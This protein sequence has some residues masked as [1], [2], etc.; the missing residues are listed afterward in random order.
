MSH[1]DGKEDK[2]E[3]GT[4]HGSDMVGVNG[5]GMPYGDGMEDGW[6]FHLLT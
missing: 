6:C 3:P 4:L 2:D 5:K 1:G